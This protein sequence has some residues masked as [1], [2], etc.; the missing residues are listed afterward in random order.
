MDIEEIAA[1][2]EIAQQLA[3]YANGVD[4]SNW[5]L[6]KS[7]FTADADLDY[8]NS[9]PLR[10]TPEDIVKEF[11]PNFAGIPWAQHYITNVTYEFDGPDRASVQAMFYNPCQLGFMDE[12]SHF[13]GHY[14]HVFVK[15]PQGWKSEKLV[16]HMH[17]QINAPQGFGDPDAVPVG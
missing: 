1:R 10:G 14:E 11:E 9:I 6:Y 2:F 12:V 5:E 4:N 13:Y 7:V 15:T 8:T 3:N 17:W 16:E